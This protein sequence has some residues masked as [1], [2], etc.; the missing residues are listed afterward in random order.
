MI[1][2]PEEETADD[3]ALYTLNDEWARE[4]EP[5]LPEKPEE[6]EETEETE[7]Q[8]EELPALQEEFPPIQEFSAEEEE[9]FPTLEE[10]PEEASPSETAAPVQEEPP[11]PAVVFHYDIKKA[12]NEI[13]LKEAFVKELVHEF[14][15]EAKAK[16]PQILAAIEDGDI[17]KV[18]SAIFEFKGLADNLRM[19][20]VAAS[21]QVLLHSSDTATAKQETERLYAMLEQL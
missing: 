4:K 10:S 17:K 9:P 16:K 19:E 2:L 8:P 15:N 13:G 3:E 5:E 14:V 12:A 6:A 21:L 11:V 18:Q 7:E 1:D 20:P